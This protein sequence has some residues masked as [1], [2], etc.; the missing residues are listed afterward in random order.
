MSKQLYVGQSNTLLQM[1]GS[2]EKIRYDYVW[3]NFTPQKKENK[4]QYNK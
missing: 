3:L 4:E 2:M 1:Q